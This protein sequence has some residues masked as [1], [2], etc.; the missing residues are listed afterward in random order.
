MARLCVPNRRYLSR[1][2]GNAMSDEL[3]DRTSYS[4]SKSKRGGSSGSGTGSK[5]GSKGSG[6]VRTGGVSSG[7][8]KADDPAA[9]L[10]TPVTRDDASTRI[11]SFKSGR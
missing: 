11:R 3:G 7:A 4:S 9:W 5:G 1:R 2:K 8:R 6:D 10:R